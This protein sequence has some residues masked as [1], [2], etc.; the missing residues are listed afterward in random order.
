MKKRENM[1]NLLSIFKT[2]PR[3]DPPKPQWDYE[4][5]PSLYWKERR[6][7][8]PV[9]NLDRRDGVVS[10]VTHWRPIQIRSHPD[11]LVSF[12]NVF[13]APCILSPE[14]EDQSFVSIIERQ[15]KE[16]KKKKNLNG[17]RK[18]K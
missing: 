2:L 13:D 15:K 5:D 18:K 17:K 8:T 14:E 9:R 10:Y 11:G 7:E 12:V 3:M 1:Y 16:E 6:I 4:T